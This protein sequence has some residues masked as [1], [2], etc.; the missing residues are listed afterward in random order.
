MQKNNKI[1]LYDRLFEVEDFRRAQWRMH[2]LPLILIIVIMALMSGYNKIRAIWDFI[3]KHT[4]DLIKYVKPKNDKLPV[5]QT[6][7]RVL[8][9]IDFDKLTC[10]FHDWAKDYVD[11]EEEE[12]YS[13]DGKW[14]RWTVTNPNNKFQK[15]TNLV[16]IFSSKRKQVLGLGKV[17]DKNNEYD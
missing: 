4:I 9:N 5:F 12:S 8:A 3:I 17:W 10:V 11:I 2:S 13:I 14:I 16:S 7:S 15:F 6:I 1:T